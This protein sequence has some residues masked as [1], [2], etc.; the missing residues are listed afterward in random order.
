MLLCGVK[1]MKRLGCGIFNSVRK[2]KK[3]V[4]LL[5]VL[6]AP[7]FVSSN[8]YALDMDYYTYNGFDAI[9]TAWQQTA[10]VFA[11]GDYAALF[12]SVIVAAIMFG[13][14]A[15]FYKI[16]GGASIHPLAWTAPILLGI[17]IYLGAFIPT[18]TLHIYDPVLN[19]YQPVSGIPDGVVLMAG[20]TN[21]IERG[22][23]EIIETSGA[24]LSYKQYAGGI[25]FDALLK[26][27]DGPFLNNTYISASVDKYITGLFVL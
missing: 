25:G 18:G 19:K 2:M 8:V 1:K 21:L 5:T 9:L 22:I 7:V 20:T 10:M 14:A 13:G 12:F 24:P 27:T 26:A 17:V 11:N 15:T 16:F 6:I 4:L 3:I 23:V